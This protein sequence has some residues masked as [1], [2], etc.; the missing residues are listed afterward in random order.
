[1]SLIATAVKVE[2]PPL[3][4]VD[5]SLKIWKNYRLMNNISRKNNLE[6]NF[7]QTKEF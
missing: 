5:V 7:H 3:V 2:G 1:V 6:G 4:A